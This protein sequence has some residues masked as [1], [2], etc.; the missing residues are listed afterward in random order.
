MSMIRRRVGLVALALAACAG[1]SLAAWTQPDQNKPQTVLFLEHRGLGVLGSDPRDAGL[2]RAVEMIPTR[3]SELKEEVPDMPPEAV[4]LF[5]MVPRMLSKPSK[6]AVAY[7]PG[8]PTGGFF[9]YGI[10]MSI[11]A[12]SEAEAIRNHERIK[13]LLKSGDA[14]TEASK[15][16]EGFTEVL[17]PPPG[18]LA[19]GVRK[20]GDVWR[21]EVA[22]GTMPTDMD[23]MLASPE[24]LVPNSTTF[25]RGT[26]DFAALTPA[27]RMILTVG[28]GNAEPVRDIAVQMRKRGLLGNDAMKLGFEMSMTESAMVSTMVYRG[29]GKYKKALYLPTEPLKPDEIR[30]LPADTVYGSLSRGDLSQVRDAI[31]EALK[32]GGQEAQGFLD[33]FKEMTGVDLRADIVD[34]LGGAYGYYMSDS[35]GGGG[36]GSL[37]YLMQIR[38][39]ERFL[40]AH[41]KLVVRGNE[42][43]E[44]AMAEAPANYIK[45]MGWKDG[46][47]Q[48]N[49]LRFNGLP[50]PM[51]FTYA[52]AGNWLVVG[53]TPQATLAAARQ[54]EG[55]G[56]AGIGSIPAVAES[57]RGGEAV[58]LGYGN[59]S[60]LVRD[61]YT[62]LSMAGSALSNAVRSPTD[63]ARD[64]GLVVPLPNELAASAR[65]SISISR[66]AG[67]DFVMSSTGDRSVVVTLGCLAGMGEKLMPIVGGL[68]AIA[69]FREMNSGGMNPMG[70]GL[71]PAA[72]ML[73][74]IE[75]WWLTPGPARVTL[76][77]RSAPSVPFALPLD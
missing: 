20:S 8:E 18:K 76:L 16:I 31:D 12:A 33:M 3:I 62:F 69:A 27:E 68:G 75:P 21:N 38:D 70:A 53:L 61:G 51:E 46:D 13:G 25:M 44:Q 77:A 9:S 14:P 10:L 32:A 59:A 39:K 60:R 74:A 23:S 37:I 34:A 72:R 66:W 2:R 5:D 28:G 63:P 48:L 42:M 50:V 7:V 65:P 58:S 11:E 30:V 24:G 36:L 19:F 29:A 54:A 17:V 1:S 52:V 73:A 47:I 6:L 71:D 4:T 40:A 43:L 26:M 15:R 56:D 57:L 45:I 55:R 64:P 67:E 41:A 35:T 22:Y 49:T